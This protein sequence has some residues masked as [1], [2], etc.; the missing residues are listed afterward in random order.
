MDTLES[1]LFNEIPTQ[2]SADAGYIWLASLWKQLTCGG[3]VVTKFCSEGRIADQW[4]VFT[5]NYSGSSM[6]F[7]SLS[8]A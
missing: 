1:D 3:I 5:M 8:F 4:P 6:T 7:V 2:S